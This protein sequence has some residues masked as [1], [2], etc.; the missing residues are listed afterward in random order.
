MQTGQTAFVAA[1]PHT[2]TYEAYQAAASQT[3]AQ[4]YAYAAISQVL[5]FI[6]VL[7]PSVV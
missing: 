1:T 4:Q 3:A 5:G 2:P 6:H 7:F